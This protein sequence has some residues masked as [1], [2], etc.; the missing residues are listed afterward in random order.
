[1]IVSAGLGL[2]CSRWFTGA[3]TSPSTT[4]SPTLPGGHL[5]RITTRRD[6]SRAR[7]PTDGCR[8]QLPIRTPYFYF[9]KRAGA[10]LTD[11]PKLSVVPPP[12]SSEVPIVRPS[13]PNRAVFLFRSNEAPP[14]TSLRRG[15]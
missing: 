3:R 6:R 9:V 4:T 10:A 13:D 1:M 12:L 8:H 14:D 11:M 5:D 2:H 15:R 7:D